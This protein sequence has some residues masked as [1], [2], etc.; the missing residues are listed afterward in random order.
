MT[1][2]RTLQGAAAVD[3]LCQLGRVS[4]AGYY[5]SSSTKPRPGPTPIC[6]TPSTASPWR[7]STTATAR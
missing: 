6:A 3:Q 2:S 1:G 5:R 7:T 4:R